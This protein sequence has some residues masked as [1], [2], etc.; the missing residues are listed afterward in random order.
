MVKTLDIDA[1]LEKNPK[2]KRERLLRDGGA[3]MTPEP[4]AFPYSPYAG[5]RLVV[6]ANAWAKAGRRSKRRSTPTRQA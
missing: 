3:P 4:R 2:V 5:R 1:L 6:D